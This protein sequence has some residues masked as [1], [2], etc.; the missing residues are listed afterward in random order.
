MKKTIFT[1]NLCLLTS[2][3]A[4]AQTIRRVNGNPGVTGINVYS[5]FA[6]AQ[7]AASA[8]D[9]IYFEPSL[10]GVG[11]NY[12]NITITKSLT[13]V[14]TGYSLGPSYNPNTPQ[15]FVNG[16]IQLG[17]V[18]I[19]KTAPNTKIEGVSIQYQISI[20]ALNSELKR[21]EI[22]GGVAYNRDATGN[23]GSN[24]K[25]VQ[26][27]IGG[28]TNTITGFGYSTSVTV[29]GNCT[30]TAYQIENLEIRNNLF[31]ISTT[32]EAQGG[33]NSVLYS[34]ICTNQVGHFSNMIFANNTVGDRQSPGQ[35]Y[36]NRCESCTAHSNI[37]N[38]FNIFPT[39]SIAASKNVCNSTCNAGANNLENVVW[40]T[41][42][43]STPITN[44]D[45]DM[46]LS[47]TSP[48]IGAGLAGVDAGAFGGPNPY[49]LS[50]IPIYPI[51][52]N[53]TLSGVGNSTTPLNV[54]V[55]V[56]GN[57]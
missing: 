43:V 52:T 9:I 2:F 19:E 31:R 42:F 35:V 8:G 37:L 21:C 10:T 53:Y 7:A 23:N 16:T 45:K 24:G 46:I 1:I 44:G 28:G 14:G 13:L 4:F 57:N 12:G 18:T 39:N 54:S 11:I 50:G 15:N 48:A 51:L 47:A 20:A 22:G 6:S 30:A 5:N 3:F 17:T 32:I 49:K 25:I 29:G 41:V 56:Q 34:G 40:N 38:S 26:C 33:I 55:T 27:R 36:I